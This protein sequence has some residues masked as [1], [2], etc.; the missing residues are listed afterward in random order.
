[1]IFLWNDGVMEWWSDARREKT[2]ET[3]SNPRTVMRCRD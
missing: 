1:M 3:D 2:E